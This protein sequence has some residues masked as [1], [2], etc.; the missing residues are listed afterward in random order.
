MTSSTAYISHQ[1]RDS[2]LNCMK[3]EVKNNCC[4]FER[5]FKVNEN[6]VFLLGISL[7]F[8]EIFRF[9]YYAN[10]E[11]DDAIGGSIKTVQ[12]SIKNIS[13][14]IKAVL[15]KLGTRNVHHKRKRMTPT[16]LLPWQHS[17][18]VSFC[19]KPN[20]PICDLLK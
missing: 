3:Y 15:F 1:I 2:D 4:L 18:P 5:L 8:L 20:T 7:F 9:L 6:G 10:E 16:M 13:R 12:H 14:N 17:A 19:E 11:N